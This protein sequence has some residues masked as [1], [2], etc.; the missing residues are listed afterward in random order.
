MQSLHAGTAVVPRMHDTLS[1]SAEEVA[2]RA[3]RA[4]AVEDVDLQHSL[5]LRQRSSAHLG[6]VIKLNAGSTIVQHRPDWLRRLHG[7][8]QAQTAQLYN[9]QHA[10]LR[11]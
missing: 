9:Q 5:C 2:G 8:T 10:E 3:L 11:L 6:S 4:R 7:R 1:R